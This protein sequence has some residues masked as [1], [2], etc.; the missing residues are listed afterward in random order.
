VLAGGA[1]PY[2]DA[3]VLAGVAALCCAAATVQFLRRDV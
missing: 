2:G 3:L 1:F